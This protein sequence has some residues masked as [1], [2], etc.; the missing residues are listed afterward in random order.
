MLTICNECSN[1]VS[2]QAE[3]C[4]HCGILLKQKESSSPTATSNAHTKQGRLIDFVRRWGEDN[5]VLGIGA[6][7]A[8]IGLVAANHDFSSGF[9]WP[10]YVELLFAVSF[11][12]YFLGKLMY[13]N[14]FKRPTV[15]TTSESIALNS[16]SFTKAGMGVAAVAL[17][18]ALL[19]HVLPGG[20]WH[21]ALD[22][23][24][25]GAIGLLFVRTFLLPTKVIDVI[26]SAA[27]LFWWLD[28]NKFVFID[29]IGH[30]G[31]FV[32]IMLKFVIA[33]LVAF[34]LWYRM[35]GA[36]A[37]LPSMII[38]PAIGL[39]PAIVYHFT[40]PTVE[41]LRQFIFRTLN[42]EN[43]S[44]TSVDVA[45][46]I[47][48]LV[49][50]PLVWL[51]F[52]IVPLLLFKRPS[53]VELEARVLSERPLLANPIPQP[54]PHSQ[55]ERA[56]AS[57]VQYQVVLVGAGKTPDELEAVVQQMVQI[58]ALPLEK[59]QAAVQRIPLVVKRNLTEAQAGSL[60][61]SLS[62]IGAQVTVEAM[63][64]P[65]LTEPESSQEGE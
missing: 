12:A 42:G 22:L 6:V 62:T 23:I 4:P 55:T 36:M 40:M 19:K 26:L 61:Q 11:A 58:F 32:D 25:A 64:R 8:V 2:D 33:G 20:D 7:V 31:H 9:V 3:S 1:N 49:I 63:P 17:I 13:A 43:V 47:N 44:T 38:A 28:H 59:A 39:I 29:A 54:D 15:D 35:T 57:D 16:Q 30:G 27:V 24:V 65:P 50:D 37:L 41:Q 46:G 18:H 14:F 5:I 52:F 21:L 60:Y 48:N 51:T 45:N 53:T 34:Y 10:K 56:S